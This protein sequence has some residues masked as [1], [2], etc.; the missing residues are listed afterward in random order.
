MSSE[1]TSVILQSQRGPGCRVLGRPPEAATTPSTAAPPK[2]TKPT[3]TTVFTTHAANSSA[4]TPSHST[5]H[6]AVVPATTLVP[7][8]SCSTH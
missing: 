6:A 1:D 3:K 5:R 4:Y 7:P 8:A 2:P